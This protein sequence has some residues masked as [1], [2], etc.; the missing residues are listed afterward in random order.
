MSSISFFIFQ[1]DL[2]FTEGALRVIA[3]NAI[4]KK[5]GARGL[6]AILEKLLLDAMFEIP[7]SNI[8]S[9]EVIL[10]IILR[11]MSHRVFR[12]EISW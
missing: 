3:R 6:R 4:S 10:Q 5:T 7:G 8:S 2:T 12:H 11:P 1:V 9:V